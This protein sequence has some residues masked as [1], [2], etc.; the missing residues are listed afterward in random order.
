MRR[1]V[2]DLSIYSFE[3]HQKQLQIILIAFVE[4]LVR[5]SLVSWGRILKTTIP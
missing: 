1:I 4:F 5:L 3:H 2:D